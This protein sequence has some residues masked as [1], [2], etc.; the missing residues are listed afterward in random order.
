MRRGNKKI[1][2]TL[3][4]G[5]PI[6]LYGCAT[7]PMKPVTFD[8]SYFQTTKTLLVNSQ[9]SKYGGLQTQ[10]QQIDILGLGVD[11]VRAIKL[12]EAVKPIDATYISQKIVEGIK[13][14]TLKNVFPNIKSIENVT[15]ISLQPEEFLLTVNVS[16]WHVFL[17]IGPF[18]M[19]FGNYTLHMIGDAKIV[20]E[21]K[22][23][24]FY[25]E[26]AVECKLGKAL[27]DIV[28]E[29]GKVI[30]ESIDESINKVVLTIAKT[31]RG[32]KG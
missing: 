23:V 10:A 19:K 22:E 4:L 17:Y 31:M 11:S 15:N 20:N 3:L 24:V 26:F 18:G 1:L 30:K 6:L 29:D 27:E 32:E 5:I 8:P 9:V 28:K 16:N 12:K 13:I 21:K 2:F 7:V 25:T 14:S